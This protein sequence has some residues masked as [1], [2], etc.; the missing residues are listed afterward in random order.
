VITLQ[1]MTW[2][3]DR[4][5]APMLATA[6]QFTE[7]HPDLRIEWEARSLQGFADHPIRDLA[8]EFDLLVLD[9]P[10]MGTVAKGGYLV[11][12]DNYLSA[13]ALSKLR[14]ESVGASHESYSYQGHQWA[15]AIDAAAQVAGYRPD[16][17]AAAGM[18]VPSTWDDVSELARI[19]KGFVTTPLLPVDSFCSFLTLCTS[20]GETPFAAGSHQ[21]V[22]KE[23]G[24][25][26]LH[27][28]KALGECAIKDAHEMNPIAVW[29][30][31]S[32]T[33]EIAYCPIAFGYSNYARRGYRRALIHFTNIPS[34]PP[35]GPA[36]SVL[37]GA[38]L[39][40]SARCRELPAAVEYV[41][42]V[43]SAECQKTIYVQSGG[44]PGNRKAWID[45]GINEMSNH[46]FEATLPTLEQAF[47]RPRF[48]GFVE[49]QTQCSFIISDFLQGKLGSTETLHSL[50]ECFRKATLVG[51][52]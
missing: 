47:L 29:E 44:Q 26:A 21:V 36:G 25:S 23:G 13:E 19:R 17:L 39:A 16:L 27:Q 35:R 40:I 42:W 10:F 1:G 52:K 4:G 38:G 32:T 34:R 6:A 14:S 24:E 31:M 2:K 50:D 33:D 7:S 45:P 3:H 9:H 20:L 46:F 37:G 28:L 22:G 30:K 15:L 8:E 43:A 51:G 48:A 49:F 11:P 18:K 41:Q 12:L 5:L